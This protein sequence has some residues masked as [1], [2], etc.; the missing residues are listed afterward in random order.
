VSDLYD[1]YFDA[2][3]SSDETE[4]AARDHLRTVF[5]ANR[6]RV[7]FSRQIEVQNEDDYFHWITNRAIHDLEGEGTIRSEWRPLRTGTSIKLV[8]HKGYR[9]YKRSAKQLVALVEEYSDPNIGGSLGLHGETMV[10]E[11]FARTQFMMISRDANEYRGK[12]WP[13]S[14]HNLDFIFERDGRAYGLEVKNTLGYMEREEFLLKIRLCKHLGITPVFVCR[15]LPKTWIFELKE[16][17]GFSL[18]LKYQLYPWTHKGLA[19]RIK[20]ELGLPVDAPRFLY[21]GTMN[22]FLKWHNSRESA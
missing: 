20:E 5:N 11:G 16:L 22:R 10:L 15:F 6:E 7:F 2:P 1:E 19:K 4:V 13:E 18:I 14:K 8:W 3:E 12:K 17:G 21:E 9:F